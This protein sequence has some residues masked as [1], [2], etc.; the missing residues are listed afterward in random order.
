MSYLLRLVMAKVY[1][2]EEIKAKINYFKD[3]YARKKRKSRG[4]SGAGRDD[5]EVVEK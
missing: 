1:T 2:L 3:Y 5:I 4:Q